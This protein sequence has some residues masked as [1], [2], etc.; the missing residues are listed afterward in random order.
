MTQTTTLQ[1]SKKEYINYVEN[2]RILES[3]NSF[4]KIVA[5]AISDYL[6]APGRHWNTSY[7]NDVNSKRLAEFLNSK[8]VE[9]KGEFA[10]KTLPSQNPFDIVCLGAGVV[11]EVKSVAKN[12]KRILSNAT[13]YPDR[14]KAKDA[15]PKSFDYPAKKEL[16]G[17]N[18]VQFPEN[19]MD[20][21]VVCVNQSK[22]V[23]SGFSI[24]DGN[25]WGVSEELYL[26]CKEYFN[27]L[28]ENIDFINSVLADENRFAD[29]ISNNIFGNAVKL[30]LRK[31][32]TLTNPVGRL[33]LRGTWSV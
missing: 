11:I 25:Y 6:S 30:N 16:F 3:K 26:S 32:I 7:K 23:V 12:N 22:D 21:L 14:V 15:L 8:F 1:A 9:F 28:N 33:N 19:Y 27:L 5:R 4:K 17:I 20:V 2:I 31:L 29:Y 18:K 10:F 24:V 13:I